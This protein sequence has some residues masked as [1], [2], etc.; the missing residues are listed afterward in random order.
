[1]SASHQRRLCRLRA[2]LCD[3]TA[4]P[5]VVASAAPAARARVAGAAGGSAF[6]TGLEVDW[7]SMLSTLPD[8]VIAE[9]PE[10]ELHWLQPFGMAVTGV[11]PCRMSA[12]AATFFETAMAIHGLVL[13]RGL[14]RLSADQQLAAASR[15]GTGV[16]YSTHKVHPAA[17][18]DAVFRLSNDEQHGFAGAGGGAQV[19]D[20]P[21]GDPSNGH[22]WHH[23]GLH[24]KAPFGHVA[25]HL[26]HVPTLGQTCF[27]HCGIAFDRLAAEDPDVINQA[28]QLCSLHSHS[29]ELRP[30]V[31]ANPVS[32]RLQILAHFGQ[33]GAVLRFVEGQEVIEG[34]SIGVEMK[35]EPMEAGEIRPIMLALYAALDS[36]ECEYPHQWEEGDLILANNLTVAHRTGPG[37]HAS[38]EEVGLRVMHRVTVMGNIDLTPSPFRP[39]ASWLDE[40]PEDEEGGRRDIPNPFGK[41]AWDASYSGIH[42][43]GGGGGGG[44]GRGVG[45]SSAADENSRH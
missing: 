15:V 42:W 45:D 17:E 2:H 5:P 31:Y 22:G 39:Y 9:Y 34:D 24:N 16:I 13:F 33:I 29:G 11:D 3:A 32:K 43:R 12:H 30:L 41:G 25:Y 19:D 6:W 4:S 23:D 18:H 20:A 37:A 7:R 36:P 38:A 21:W 1:M 8:E 40:E 27:A 10:A 28:A 35:V 14:G 26:P 44:G